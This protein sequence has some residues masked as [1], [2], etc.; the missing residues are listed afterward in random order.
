VLGGGNIP[1]AVLDGRRWDVLRTKLKGFDIRAIDI[2]SHGLLD[3]VHANDKTVPLFFRYEEALSSSEQAALDPYPHAFY[4]VGMRTTGQA[5]FH[6]RSHCS[7]L[8]LRYWH[9]SA[10]QAYKTY[11]TD[12][13]QHGDSV[14]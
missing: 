11:Y 8:L 13:F 9:W 5:L 14:L 1:G 12:S 3:D 6:Q 7:N 4:E 2:N 10:I